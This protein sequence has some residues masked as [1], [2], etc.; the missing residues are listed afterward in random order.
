MDVDKDTYQSWEA[1]TLK[2][3][4][5]KVRRIR[6]KRHLQSDFFL[7]Q[8]IAEER[9]SGIESCQRSPMFCKW[10]RY[11]SFKVYKFDGFYG[12]GRIRYFLGKY[13]LSSVSGTS[14]LLPQ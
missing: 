10:L 4:L 12:I 5:K 6:K 7:P 11:N 2:G 13:V 3:S 14:R 9:V 8:N 1:C